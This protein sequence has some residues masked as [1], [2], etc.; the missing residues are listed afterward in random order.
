MSQLPNVTSKVQLAKRLQLSPGLPHFAQGWLPQVPERP[1]LQRRRRWRNCVP[2]GHSVGGGEHFTHSLCLQSR[3]LWL[4]FGRLQHVS[5]RVFLYPR[6]AERVSG[7]QQQH[8]AGD[9]L[10]LPYRVPPLLHRRRCCL[11]CHRDRAERERLRDRAK[12]NHATYHATYHDTYCRR[13]RRG[14]R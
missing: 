1:L 10:H 8:S 9:G 4:G 7:A 2:V 11:Y 3:A 12:R 5:R 13:Y 14:H 6:G